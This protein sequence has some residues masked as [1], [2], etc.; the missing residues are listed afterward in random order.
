MVSPVNVQVRPRATTVTEISP[1]SMVLVLP[2]VELGAQAADDVTLPAAD[3]TLTEITEANKDAQL[4]VEGLAPRMYDYIESGA[5][6]RLWVLPFPVLRADALPAR[7]AKVVTALNALDKTDERAKLPNGKVDAIV[8]PRETAIGQGANVVVAKLKTFGLDTSLGAVSFVD[9][10]VFANRTPTAAEPAQADAIA[11]ENDNADPNVLA[12]TNRAD[13]AG[14]SGVFGSIIAAGHWARYTSQYGI[15]H[16]PTNL[17][18]VVVGVS[19]ITPDRIFNESDGSS[20][21]VVLAREPLTSIITWNGSHYL[22]GG[23]TKFQAS[24]PREELSNNIVAHRIVKEA[25]LDLAPFVG[26]RATRANLA[27]LQVKLQD[28]ITAG[29]VPE[30]IAAVSVGTPILAGGRLSVQME[31]QFFDFIDSITLIAEVFV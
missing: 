17:R 21:A 4:G 1:L 9:A 23:K 22:W 18:D 15:H 30:A 7:L 28:D 13:A 29:Y 20:A 8:L 2:K 16:Q 11:W 25:T 26:L 6:V 27:A 12:V 24:D 14:G 3:S 10:G 5:S 31:V 19:N